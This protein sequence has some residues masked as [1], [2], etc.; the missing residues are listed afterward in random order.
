MTLILTAYP[1]RLIVPDFTNPQS[2]KP[3]RLCRNN[4]L[5]YTIPMG[6]EKIII[7]YGIGYSKPTNSST[8]L[9]IH[10]IGRH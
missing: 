3:L 2:L 4:P 7:V 8:L 5:K 9:L 10:S 6:F 1:G